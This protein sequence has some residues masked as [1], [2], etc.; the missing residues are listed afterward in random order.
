[1]ERKVKESKE[2]NDT[3]ENNNVTETETKSS[4]SKPNMDAYTTCINLCNWSLYFTV[5]GTSAEKMIK[6]NGSIDLLN[7]EI[8]LLSDNNDIFFVGTGNGNHARVYIE[9][10]NMRIYCGFDS[11]DGKRKQNILNDEK[12]QK[13]F[14][15]KTQSTFEKN[16]QEEVITEAE[17]D[18]I[19]S[20]AR[21]NKINDFEK[22][23]YLES[24]THRKYKV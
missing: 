24:Y 5:P 16:I 23:N 19:M 1:M 7:R 3:Q 20:Y 12:C 10:D 6:A 13:L 22:I 15:Y 4:Y 21:K 8:K 2:V 9:D 17:K 14:D 11:E 18:Y